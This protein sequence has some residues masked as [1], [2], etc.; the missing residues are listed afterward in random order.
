MTDRTRPGDGL[1]HPVALGAL[2]LLVVNDQWL[3]AAWPGP[4][5]GIL[6]DIA[7]LVVAP[8]AVQ[9][10]W[11]V[12]T[13]GLG[14]WTGP[15]RRV[16]AVAIALVAVGFVLLQVWPPATQAYRVGLGWLQWPFT[17]A[18]SLLRDG[19]LPP[20]QPVVAVGDVEDLLALPALAV[21]W[22]AGSRRGR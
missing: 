15:S 12:A 18:A 14:R 17:A 21:S 3:K 16:L 6:S 22:W 7:G 8:L 11:E 4:V 5:T 9:A 2:V 1:L 20:A 10:V 19:T 13:W